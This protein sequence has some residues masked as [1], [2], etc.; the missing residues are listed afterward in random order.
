MFMA[1]NPPCGSIN[2]QLHA[3]LW[4]HRDRVTRSES[5]DRACVFVESR[6][7][8]SESTES[9]L[10]TAHIHPPICAFSNVHKYTRAYPL[11]HTRDSA[12]CIVFGSRG[13][14]NNPSSRCKTRMQGELGDT[15]F[16][17]PQKT[18][19]LSSHGAS[20]ILPGAAH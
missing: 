13:R 20:G 16:T 9:Q 10:H 14:S 1:E 18:V 11:M 6:V 15:Y 5:S 19:P 3:S 17:S 8:R 2:D 7:T 12:V 4:G